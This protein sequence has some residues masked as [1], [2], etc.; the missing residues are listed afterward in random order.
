MYIAYTKQYKTLCI[1]VELIEW[2]IPLPTPIADRERPPLDVAWYRES[3]RSRN[4]LIGDGG[5]VDIS[6]FMP[7]IH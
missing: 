5:Y 1:F 6:A 4:M 3:E 2:G 7:R